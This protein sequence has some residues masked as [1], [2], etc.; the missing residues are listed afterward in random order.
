MPQSMLAFLAMTIVMM[1]TLSQR[2]TDIRSHESLVENE[3]EIMAN[4]LAIEQMEI[5]IGSTAWEDLE[6][7]DDSVSTKNFTFTGF[8]E[9]FQIGVS[10]QFVDGFGNPSIVPTTIKEVAISAMNDRYVLP[11]VTHARLVS[12]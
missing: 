9:S 5:V 11:L 6:N 7:W 4:A 3:F 8:Q 1:I 10:I 12:E 2:R